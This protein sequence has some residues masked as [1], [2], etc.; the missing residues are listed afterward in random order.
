MGKEI[1]KLR[2]E[3]SKI[4]VDNL[5]TYGFIRKQL[6][7][8]WSQRNVTYGNIGERLHRIVGG[9][10]DL[11]GNLFGKRKNVSR[12][13]TGDKSRSAIRERVFEFLDSLEYKNLAQTQK[14]KF[15][16]E[17]DFNKKKRDLKGKLSIIYLDTGKNLFWIKGKYGASHYGR[18]RRNVY[19]IYG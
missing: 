2:Q 15:K 17:E 16:N 14:E 6:S 1:D 3:L 9:L 19:V 11:I 12:K 8:K 5:S 7:E 13:F 4:K 18:R 10:N